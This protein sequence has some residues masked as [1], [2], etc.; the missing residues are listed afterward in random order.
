MREALLALHLLGAALW[1]GPLLAIAV[2]TGLGR[3]SEKLDTIAFAYRAAYTTNLLLVVPGYL[4][5]VISGLFLL[6]ETHQRLLDP[7]S[8]ELFVM[9]V[10]GLA[11]F[12][13]SVALADRWLLRLRQLAM[14]NAQN[15]VVNPGF[16]ALQPLYAVV[17][18]VVGIGLIA[19]V[20][21]GAVHA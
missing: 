20:V 1:L 17:A 2:V 6:Y 19:A 10:I 13:I 7:A 18:S 9:Q 5:T 12:A 11:A 15:G 21:L 4:L 16:R 8:G 14:W 3:R